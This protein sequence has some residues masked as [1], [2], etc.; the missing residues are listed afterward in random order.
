MLRPGLGPVKEGSKEA[1]RDTPA[2]SVILNIGRS[3]YK[4]PTYYNPYYRDPPKGTSTF[5]NPIF[6]EATKWTTM[7]ECSVRSHLEGAKRSQVDSCSCVAGLEVP[8]ASTRRRAIRASPFP[9]KPH[10]AS[11]TRAPE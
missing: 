1:D 11:K 10:G 6:S 5:G 8:F 4:T 9:S 7:K 2:V 3:Q